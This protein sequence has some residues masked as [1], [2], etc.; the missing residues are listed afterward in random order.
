MA[1]CDIAS[2]QGVIDLLKRPLRKTKPRLA[3]LK[4]LPANWAM[5]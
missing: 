2:P 4:L 3:K 1:L 5:A